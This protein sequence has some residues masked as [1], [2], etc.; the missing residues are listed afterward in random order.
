MPWPDMLRVLRVWDFSPRS[1]EVPG[2]G[3]GVERVQAVAAQH[4]QTDRQLWVAGRDTAR[5]QGPWCVSSRPNRA[6]SQA[7]V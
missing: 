3:T 6:L 7:S 5:M 2:S 4:S 1:V